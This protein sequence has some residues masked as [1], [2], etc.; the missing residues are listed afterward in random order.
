MQQARGYQLKYSELNPEMHSELSRRRK[1]ATMLAV[2]GESMGSRLGGCDVLNLG[3]STGLIDEQLAPFVRSVMGVDIDEPG[4]LAAR[5]RT[6][7]RANIEFMIADA[8]DLPFPENSF[9]VVICSQVYEHV[10]NAARMMA[11]VHR[12][13]RTGGA[14]YFAA[15]NRWSLIEQHYHLPFLSWLPIPLA[16]A[17]LRALGRSD[18][19]YER[20][21]GVPGLRKL[22]Q[23]M[24]I[25]DWTGRILAHPERYG[26]EY[27]FP[28]RAKR[29]VSKLVYDWAYYLFPGFIW[30]L[31]KQDVPAADGPGNKR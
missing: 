10:P 24:R 30:L 11:E 28:T 2:L 14:C 19:Y 25:E 8:M 5:R 29:L 3:C 7:G 21:L 26:A 15:T 4:I 23:P 13:L 22:T 31:W 18:A 12:V 1:A 17:Y 16:S 27:M 9:D 20:H 6:T